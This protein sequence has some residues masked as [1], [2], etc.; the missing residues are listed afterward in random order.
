MPAARLRGAV[1]GAAQR[2]A[3]PREPAAAPVPPTAA[4]HMARHCPA[5]AALGRYLYL[6]GGSG[7]S[8]DAEAGL[9]AQPTAS[10]ERLE[11]ARFGTPASFVVS[12]ESGAGKTETSRHG[13]GCASRGLAA[14]RTP[15]PCAPCAPRVPGE[16][17]VQE[18]RAVEELCEGV[19]QLHQVAGGVE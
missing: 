5:A 2:A 3:E 9:G 1:A 17:W 8:P 18:A 10:V 15:A 16:R 7:T 4:L 6:T 19:Q 13:R 14:Q 12:G 11:L